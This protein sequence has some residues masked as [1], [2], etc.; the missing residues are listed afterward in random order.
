MSLMAP[1]RHADETQSAA[2]NEELVSELSTLG[3]KAFTGAVEV[4][5]RGT[6]NRARLFLYDGGLY[7]VDLEGYPRAVFA[8]LRTAGLLA[9]RSAAELTALAGLDIP[10]P[11]VITHAIDRQW[12][13]IDDLA[14]VHQELLL[15]SLGAVLVLPKV[16]TRP[17]KGQTSAEFCTLPLPVDPLFD[18]VRMRADR[19]QGTWAML[20]PGAA[21][22]HAVLSRT[23]VPLDRTALSPEVTALA[24]AVDGTRSLDVIAH[25]LGL[26]RAEVVHVASALIRSGMARVEIDVPEATEPAHYLVPEAFG[27]HRVVP[28]VPERVPQLKQKPPTP[29]V[30]EPP[31]ESAVLQAVVPTALPTALPMA[32]PLRPIGDVDERER[33]LENARADV[34]RLHTELQACV[35]AEQ[36]AINATAE[37]SQRLRDAR[38]TLASLE[39]AE[40]VGLA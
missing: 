28:V 4:L 6:R 27:S 20:A 7:A 30:V 22:G 8:R 33:G 24:G 36:E 19:L 32:L 1:R 26:T 15:A 10:D 29:V 18:T 14:N 39:M 12:I 17:R 21:P 40:S 13:S 34:T 35:R 3:A 31:V 5:D 16:K 11:T 23:L 25:A 2:I 9:P 38:V 37:V